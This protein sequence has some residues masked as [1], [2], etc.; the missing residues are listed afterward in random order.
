MEWI[1]LTNVGSTNTYLLERLSKLR[2]PTVVTANHQTAG[3]GRQAKVWNSQPGMQL[4]FSVYWPWQAPYS[5]APLSLAVAKVL[6][7]YLTSYLTDEIVRV[8]W[9]NDLQ[10]NGLKL[11]GILLETQSQ[12]FK[13]DL[14]IG[15]GLNY[16]PLCHDFR[17][18]MDQPIASLSDYSDSLPSREA[19]LVGLVDEIS[20]LCA[21]AERFGF[22]ALLEQWKEIDALFGKKIEVTHSTQQ[23][24]G[25]ADGI[26]PSGALRL[27]VKDEVQLIYSGTVREKGSD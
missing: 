23:I 13:T 1:F 15:V 12:G 5:P 14:V 18:M 9:P 3:R 17:A 21:N 24:S 11:A 20:A 27:R 7:S 4:L 19:L 10:I 16:G 26:D 8:K 22:Q 25:V 2:G 6:A